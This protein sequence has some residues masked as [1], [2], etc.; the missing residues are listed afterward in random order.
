[1]S[2]AAK[3]PR[4]PGKLRPCACGEDGIRGRRGQ[5]LLFASF[6][7]GFRACPARC[8]P[9]SPAG[10][11]AVHRRDGVPWFTSLVGGLG[12]GRPCALYG[13][14]NSA[15]RPSRCTPLRTRESATRD[16]SNCCAACVTVRPSAGKI[17]SRRVRSKSWGIVSRNDTRTKG[18]HLWMLGCSWML[19][20]CPA[21]ARTAR[22]RRQH[23]QP[24]RC[25]GAS[26][27]R[28]VHPSGR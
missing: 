13:R 16:T 7:L 28:A 17:S 1:M 9:N 12:S 8:E 19:A 2:A 27:Q 18:A 11:A 25:H 21:S 22:R 5:V 24:D 26:W 23:V 14:P 6:L 10:R 15:S 3:Q 20:A 4:K